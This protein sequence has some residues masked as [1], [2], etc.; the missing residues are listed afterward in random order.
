MQALDFLDTHHY[1][2]E[3]RFN[4]ITR[5]SQ[6]KGRCQRARVPLLFQKLNLG[7]FDLKLAK[8]PRFGSLDACTMEWMIAGCQTNFETLDGFSC[9][10]SRWVQQPRFHF[11][12]ATQNDLAWSC[13]LALN[14]LLL[15]F[16]L[17]SGLVVLLAVDD[18]FIGI[19]F[20]PG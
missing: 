5:Q 19:P 2:Y 14:E 11:Q 10:D 12:T 1:S 4:V 20:Q 3:L 17:C 7:L 15:L 9:G 13:R 18:G 6:T 16:L 8:Y